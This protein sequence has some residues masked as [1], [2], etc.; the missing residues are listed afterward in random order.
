MKID[1]IQPNYSVKNAQKKSEGQQQYASNQ[2]NFKGNI[3]DKIM[4][5]LKQ[6]GAIKFMKGLEWLKGE[7]GG[8]L[9]T[10]IGTG[11]VAPWFIAF[12]PFVKAKP[13]ATQEEK[14]ELQ[15]TKTYT[16]MRQ[17]ISAVLA[18]MIQLGLLTPI[19]RGLD[20]LI[21]KENFA[22]NF[23]PDLDQSQINTKSFIKR[24]VEKAM[25]KEGIKKPS[26]LNI[27]KDGWSK[28]RENSKAYDKIVSD[29]VGEA[30]SSQIAKIAKSFGKTGEI[31][32]PAGKISDSSIA[33]LVNKQIEEYI[34]DAEALKISEKGMEFYSK[35]AEVLIKNETHL[36]SIFDKVPEDYKELKTF[37]E[38]LLAKEKNA[39]VK[40]LIKEI[41]DRPED[42]RKSR[43]DR[44]FE[45][46][47]NIKDTCR[48]S[49]S[50][51]NYLQAMKNRNS[52]L[53]KIIKELNGDK[54]ADIGTATK[55]SIKATLE[56]VAKTCS[57]DRKNSL[58]HTILHDTDTFHEQSEEI[59]KKM[60]KD[61]AKKY[62][63]MVENSYKSFNQ[64][65]KVLIGVF[66]TLPITCNLLNWVYP[67]FMD[68]FFPKLSGAKKSKEGGNK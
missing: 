57:Y 52:E 7:S 58:L 54:I 15:N 53:D 2:V 45:R 47:K 19:D 37:L 39:D 64:P 17:P 25:K 42:I 5:S 11:L 40:E 1:R 50:K 31:V 49:Y 36:R 66:I 55:D 68:L 16:A 41:L 63:K 34:S 32:V 10:A 46:I 23:R 22:K 14:K 4:D 26:V 35:R 28:Y 27:F 8:I 29:R 48:G 59:F 30:Q 65:L 18:I 20:A 21:N 56:K 9:I 33:K 12:N 62:K 51:E 60:S 44:T 67:R 3:E 6:K 61:V 24:N 38:N 13:G 43:I